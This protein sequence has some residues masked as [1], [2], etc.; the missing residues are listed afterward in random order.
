MTNPIVQIQDLG[1]RAVRRQRPAIPGTAYVYLSRGGRFYSPP[2]GLTAGESWW[3]APTRM[4]VVDM[5]PHPLGISHQLRSEAADR[6]ATV[7]L[8]ARWRTVAPCAVVE[9]RVFDV[10]TVARQRLHDQ[11]DQAVAGT[12]W[13]L[14]TQLK[15]AL[16]RWVLPLI[17]LPEGIRL[18]DIHTEVMPFGED[19]PA[20]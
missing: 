10:P 19:E 15:T 8:T 7:E 12:F 18:Y 14:A 5:T 13:Q 2:G 9:N 17:D 3:R 1:G 16:D 20:S 11:L 4:Y 6:T